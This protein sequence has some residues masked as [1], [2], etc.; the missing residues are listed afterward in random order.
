M[1]H[2]IQ[3]WLRKSN[4]DMAEDYASVRAKLSGNPSQI[5]ISGSP[6]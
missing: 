3:E 5:Q 4:Q 6:G 2:E 1:A